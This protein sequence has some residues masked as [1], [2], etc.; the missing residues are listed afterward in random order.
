MSSLQTS[1]D[2]MF[3]QTKFSKYFEW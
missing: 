2:D 3:Y 1:N